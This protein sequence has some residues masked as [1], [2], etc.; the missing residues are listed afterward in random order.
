MYF[1]LVAIKSN[2][3][4]KPVKII[5]TSVSFLFK[6]HAAIGMCACVCVGVC[7]TPFNTSALYDSGK[8]SKNFSSL[9]SEHHRLA[10]IAH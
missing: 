7:V 10:L 4:N 6:C 8:F 1:F 9:G 5:R 2:K 3:R